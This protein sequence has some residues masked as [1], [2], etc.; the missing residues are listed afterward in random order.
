[1]ER[2]HKI[3][4]NAN[5][6]SRRKA[7][8]LILAGRVKVNG[9]V[10][11]T[12]GTKVSN[13]DEIL[14]DDKAILKAEKVYILMNK[15][16]G[17]SSYETEEK[18]IK[19]VFDLLEPEDRNLRLYPVGRL[20]FDTAGILLLTNDGE[21]TYKLTNSESDIEKEYLVRVAGIVIRKKIQSLRNNG[22]II[23]KDYLVKP[24][25]IRIL[26]LNKEA[27]TTL[28]AILLV[29]KRTKEV[30]KIFEA[31]G[32]K[33]KKMT[34]IKYDFLSL[35]VER[36]HYRHLKPHEIKKLY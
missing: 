34:R 16:T 4:A 7:E 2:L 28:I 12:L 11:T 31:I 3:I 27:Q 5:I 29:E 1:M 22:V 33:V 13:K 23:D 21:L 36:G 32:H 9:I 19:T 8:E 14:V 24:K 6:A 20:D 15:P 30:K 17:Y 18:G 10:I 25:E 26:E 35:D